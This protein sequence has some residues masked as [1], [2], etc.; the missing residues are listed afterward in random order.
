MKKRFHISINVD[1]VTE[2]GLVSVAGIG[3]T[4][5]AK[6]VT[7]ILN[8][9]TEMTKLFENISLKLDGDD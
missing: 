4:I 5:A 3:M 1:E 9:V 7:D 8:S 2:V 6:D